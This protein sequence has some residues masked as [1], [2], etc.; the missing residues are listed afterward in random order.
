MN[1]LS[2]D[3]H[4]EL[5]HHAKFGEDRRLQVRKCGVCFLFV[6]H[7][8]SPE[9]VCAF[10]GCIVRTSIA[11]LFIDGF[12]RGFRHFLTR[13][14]SIGNTSQ[15]AYSLLGVATIFAKLRSIIAK[16]PKIGGE[17]C[18][19][20]FVQVAEGFEKNSTAVVQGRD[21]RCAP[22]YNFSARRYIALTANYVSVV[23]KRLGMNKFV[24][25]K[26]HRESKFSKIF[27]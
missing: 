21:C 24:R 2:F 4:D 16:S 7:A 27:F 10:Q 20:H 25:T 15:F 14:C 12:R 11:L 6:C 18:A 26:R 17:V 8:P 19:H 3:G 9:H 1:N 13:D 22:T 5:Y 23:Q